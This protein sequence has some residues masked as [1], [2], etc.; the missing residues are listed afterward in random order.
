MHR[1]RPTLNPYPHRYSAAFA[2]SRI[3]YPLRRRTALRRPYSVPWR[4]QRAYPVSRIY[5]KRHRCRLSTGGATFAWFTQEFPNLAPCLLAQACQPLW[6]V[7]D[8]D[9][10]NDSL[11]FILSLSPHPSAVRLAESNLPR[12]RFFCY[13]SARLTLSRRLRTKRLP[14]MH[15]PVGLRGETR[16]ASAPPPWGLGRD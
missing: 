16:T 2:F 8:D 11:P 4:A 7:P 5:R 15:A 13:T 3:L 6:L 9:G 14:A 10:Y 12:G 1:R